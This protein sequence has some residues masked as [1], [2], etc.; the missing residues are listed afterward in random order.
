MANPDIALRSLRGTAVLRWEY[1][2]GGTIFLVWNQSRTGF[3][4]SGHFGGFGDFP[5]VLDQ[6]AENI[7]LVKMS[8]WFSR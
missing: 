3:E 1:M 4:P 6:P 5:D 8:Y 2:P 7:F